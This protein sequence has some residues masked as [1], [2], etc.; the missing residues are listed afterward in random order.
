[1]KC[2]STQGFVFGIRTGG[3]W[4]FYVQRKALVEYFHRS[5][6]LIGSGSV[7]SLGK[8][9]IVRQVIQFWPAAKA[10]SNA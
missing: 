5:R 10:G 8:Q 3:D 1:M 9:W 2:V 4:K 7:K 6:A